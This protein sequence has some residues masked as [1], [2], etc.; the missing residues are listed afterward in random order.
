MSFAYKIKTIDWRTGYNGSMFFQIKSVIPVLHLYREMVMTYGLWDQILVDQG[1][2][3]MLLLFINEHLSH[4]RND[5]SRPPHL[6]SSSKQVAMLF[7]VGII[8]MQMYC[9]QNHM[10][11]HIWVEVNSRV[12]YPIKKVLVD[13]LNSG[14]FSLDREMHKICVSWLTVQVASCGIELFVAGC[15]NHPIPGKNLHNIMTL[16]YLT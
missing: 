6:Q 15:N 1:K 11:E 8:K 7:T 14:D 4:L 2:E 16:D 12:N 5:C 13:M 9:Q 10:V 3:W